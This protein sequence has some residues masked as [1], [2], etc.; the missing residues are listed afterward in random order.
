M[1]MRY[2]SPAALFLAFVVAC[3]F[4][5]TAQKKIPTAEQILDVT[6]SQGTEFWI[7]IPPNEINP[8]QTDQ[9]EIYVAS[10]F[11][12]EVEVST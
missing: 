5:A 10:A 11:D 4:G 7:A 3:T 1:T 2:L 9:L 6:G 8:Y 12:G